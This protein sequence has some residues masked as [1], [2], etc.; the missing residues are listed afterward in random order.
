MFPLSLMTANTAAP[1]IGTNPLEALKGWMLFLFFA[2]VYLVPLNGRLLWQPDETRYA[3]ISREM[4]ASGDWIVPRLLGLRYFEKPVAGYWIN[5]L[6]QWLFGDSN[7][8][9]RFGSVF[10]TALSAVLVFWLAL[11]LWRDRSKALLAGA[12]YLSCF[13]V[14]A[15][16]TYGALDAMLA[17]WLTAA[18]VCF[19]CAD[20]AETRRGKAAAYALLGAA[21]GMGLMTKGFLALA[22][23]VISVLPYIFWRRI[24]E[25]MGEYGLRSGLWRGAKEL[26]GYGAIAIAAAAAISAPW[27]IAVHLREPDYWHY[28]FWIE[29]IQRFAA[30]NAQHKKPFWFFLPILAIGVLPWLGLLPSA[31][32]RGWRKRGVRPELFSL[33]CWAAM[34]FLFFSAAKGK[35]PTYILPCFAPLAL[36]MA[37]AAVDRVKEGRMAAL[38]ANG[39]INLAAGLLAA[40]IVG[41]LVVGDS[42]ASVYQPGDEAKIALALAAFA[43]WSAVGL[44][45]VRHC[46]RRWW[47]AALCPLLLGLVIGEAIPQKVV[48]VKQPQYLI[49]DIRHELAASRYILGSNVG[50]ALGL[51]W[52]TKRSDILL[53][54]TRG[55]LSYGLRYPDGAA[56]FVAEEGF[57]GWLAKARKEGDVSLLLLDGKPERLPVPDR[58]VAPENGPAEDRLV[59]LYYRRQP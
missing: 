12:I 44:W 32:A 28:F 51:A 1:R 25:R 24:R 6:G 57:A 8:A 16:G 53:F 41:I 46:A 21:C 42:R 7:F 55:E 26:L 50:I 18:M 3:E 9:V 4:L 47:C 39:W 56:R 37:D 14:Y 52:E 17:L 58:T 23:P 48:A 45:T 36:L 22:V 35:L 38:R 10:C 2:V 49:N 54:G 5:N 40:L 11:R 20:H 19:H 30:D 13:I 27:A 29:H 15:I 34:P 33:L 59:F 43:A 31:L